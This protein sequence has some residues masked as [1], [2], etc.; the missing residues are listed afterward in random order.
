MVTVDPFDPF[1]PPGL[2][3][4]PTYPPSARRPGEIK[5]AVRALLRLPL[6]AHDVRHGRC[7]AWAASE[8]DLGA[9]TDLCAGDF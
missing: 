4:L 3:L 6:Y 9:L 2:W 5:P 7:Q 8:V 1:V